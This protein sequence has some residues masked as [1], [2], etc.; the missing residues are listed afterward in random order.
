MSKKIGIYLAGSIKKGHENP[1]ESF[2][3]EEDMACLQR[4]FLQ[5]E[6]IFLNPA[7]RM[8]NLADQHSVFGRDMTQVFCSHVVFV[9][10]RDRRGLGVGA[11]MMWAKLNEIPVVTWSPKNSHYNKTKTT[12]LG[13]E[14]DHFIHP[15]VHGLSDKIVETLEEGALWI[16]QILSD[17]SIEIKGIRHIHASMEYYQENQLPIDFPMREI[18]SCDALNARLTRPLIETILN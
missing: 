6:V 18:L 17:P 14:V 16:E 2:W 3:T 9:D 13:K 1:Q 10:A 15:F 5:H 7:F 4:S 12:I 8:D 11:E